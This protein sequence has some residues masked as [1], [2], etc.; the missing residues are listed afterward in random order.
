MVAPIKVFAIEFLRRVEDQEEW[1]NS[2]RMQTM[3]ATENK[4]DPVH[5]HGVKRKKHIFPI[6]ILASRYPPL[7][8]VFSCCSLGLMG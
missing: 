6:A 2:W 7:Q 4:D 1:L 8:L 3:W 5:L